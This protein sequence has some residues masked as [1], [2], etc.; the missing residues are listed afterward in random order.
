MSAAP[1]LTLLAQIATLGPLGHLRPAPGTIGALVAVI[2]GYFIGGFGPLA[3]A[4]AMLAV[5]LL[6]VYAAAAYS[7]LTGKKDPS[8]VIIDEVAGQWLTLI[9][10]P[11]DAVWYA[12]GFALFRFFDILKPGP[13]HHAERLR[14]GIGV[15]ADDV[16]AGG[17]AA[18]CLA[19]AGFAL[20]APFA[21]M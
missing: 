16:V 9:I 2:T 17:L 21:L 18:L 4:T 11:H 1:R 7:Q 12:A 10:L 8:E 13:V 6:G 14:G 3:L 20:D 15:M 5:S 19:I